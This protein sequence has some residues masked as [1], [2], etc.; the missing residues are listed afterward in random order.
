MLYETSKGN[1]NSRRSGLE[2]SFTLCQQGALTEQQRDSVS[3]II[4]GS[5]HYKYIIQRLNDKKTA[6]KLF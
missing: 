2:H 1:R 5:E 4:I 3:L 6:S